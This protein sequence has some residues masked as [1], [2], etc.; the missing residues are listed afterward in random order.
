ML[1]AL[2]ENPLCSLWLS[3]RLLAASLL[4]NSFRQLLGSVEI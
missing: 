1:G 4:I 2:Y 3:K